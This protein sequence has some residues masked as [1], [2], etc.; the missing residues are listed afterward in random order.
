MIKNR[1]DVEYG[2]L[3]AIREAGHD[4]ANKLLWECLCKCGKTVYVRANNLASGNTTSC[5]CTKFHGYQEISLGYWNSLK[6]KANKRKLEFSITIEDGWNLFLKQNRKCYLS[7]LDIKFV[8]NI[9][10]YELQNASLDRIDSNIG[11]TINNIAWCDKE[12]NQFKQDFT[13][14]KLLEI[15]HK[16]INP[17]L[18]INNQSQI[19][20]RYFGYLRKCAKERNISFDITKQDLQNKFDEQL[21]CCKYTGI[22][23]KFAPKYRDDVEIQNLSVDRLNSNIGYTK[24]NI[25]YVYKPINKLKHS[26]S[27]SKFL[28][29]VSLI[30]NYSKGKEDEVV[31]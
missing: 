22:Q 25:Q 6:R 23:L 19:S 1:K 11:Y 21:G 14:D 24:N 4:K 17:V 26:L 13:N 27:E 8:R 3:T 2:L 29:F 28:E 20:N 31:V 30:Y 12:I 7:G 16:I 18:C 5:G 9:D 10:N 15:C